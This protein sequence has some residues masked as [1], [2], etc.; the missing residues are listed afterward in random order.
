MVLAA[1][2]ASVASVALVALVQGEGAR[3]CRSLARK[4][5]SLK[6]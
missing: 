5:H 2:V 4:H 3:L 6:V 1:S